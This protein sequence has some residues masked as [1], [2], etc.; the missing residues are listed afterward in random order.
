MRGVNPNVTDDYEQIVK[1]IGGR[2][3]DNRQLSTVERSG[4]LECRAD[5]Y[6]ANRI[7]VAPGTPSKDSQTRHCGKISA[8]LHRG[9][10]YS[11]RAIACN[12]LA[13]AIRFPA[14]RRDHVHASLAA[15]RNT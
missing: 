15:R 8:D 2:R 10:T 6:V 5:E 3:M 7:V 14:I 12:I 9:S 1:A 13:V 11:C 4:D